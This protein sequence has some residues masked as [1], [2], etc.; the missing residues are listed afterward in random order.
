MRAASSAQSATLRSN[1]ATSAARRRRPSWNRASL[2]QATFDGQPAPQPFACC[3]CRQA[4]FRYVKSRL[5]S[6][7]LTR[8][9]IVSS[10]KVCKPSR[11][12]ADRVPVSQKRTSSTGAVRY[13]ADGHP[14]VNGSAGGD[15]GA[16][17]PE[18]QA[19]VNQK[20]RDGVKSGLFKMPVMTPEQ[21][22]AR[23]QRL[24]ILRSQPEHN[25][26][27]RADVRAKNAES[28][29]ARALA[30]GCVPKVRLRRGSAE[31]AAMRSAIEQN[32]T[33]DEKSAISRKISAALTG[34]AKT[35]THREALRQAGL[36]KK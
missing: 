30:R 28:Q 14:L 16:L 1:R 27:K 11:R 5:C 18:I 22:S 3:S 35:S 2:F 34:K 25:P 20:L 31:H 10:S 32:R 7:G 13:R 15:G 9:A 33:A 26:M 23:N 6:A 12:P 21:A 29:R 8:P 24:S 36:R 4:S 19:R 17:L